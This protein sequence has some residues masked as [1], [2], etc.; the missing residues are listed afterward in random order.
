MCKLVTN[1]FRYCARPKCV[2]LGAG[3]E[4]NKC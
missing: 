4:M 1:E 3:L 2:R